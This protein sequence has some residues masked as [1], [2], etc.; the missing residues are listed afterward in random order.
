[1]ALAIHKL[2]M[3][4]YPAARYEPFNHPPMDKSL[5]KNLRAGKKAKDFRLASY[6]MGEESLE[7]AAST[8]SGS[9][10]GLPMVGLGDNGCALVCEETLYP[11]KCVAYGHYQ[12]SGKEDLC[13]IFSEVQDVETFE[14]PA[15]FVQ[16]SFRKAGE[17][18]SATCKIKMSEIATGY[19]P[20]GELKRNKRCFGACGGFDA[21]VATEDYGVPDKV[22]IQGKEVIEKLP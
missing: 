14:P 5:R 21:R 7:P 18:A 12:V 2:I 15:S 9:I 8:C 4:T 13:F 1:M 11:E 19:M 20:K 16:Q 10:I 3:D 17:A 6:A 22:E